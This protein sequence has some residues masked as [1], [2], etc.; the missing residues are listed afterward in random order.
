MGIVLKLVHVPR[1]LGHRA[2]E[3]ADE[4][5]AL[6]VLQEWFQATLFVAIY[7]VDIGNL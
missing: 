4:I 6:Y 3:G 1:L 2:V 7:F 5:S